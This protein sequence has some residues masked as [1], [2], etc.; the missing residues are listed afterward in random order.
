M[1][2]VLDRADTKARLFLALPVPAQA[3][4]RLLEAAARNFSTTIEALTQEQNLHVTLFFFGEVKNHAQYLGWLKQ[5]LPQA[6]VPTV[7]I[8]HIGRGAA[9]EQ[10]WAYVTP[11]AGLMA[12]RESLNEKLRKI[13]FPRPIQAHKFTPHIR[14]AT[15][16]PVAR[17][18]GI[19]DVAAPMTFAVPEAHLYKSELSHV[20][21]TYHI[22][23]S[24]A[25]RSR[26]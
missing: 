1:I 17:G 25:L 18:M 2:S 9:R 22:E 20:G 7:T 10:L 16:L 23:C 5:G 3:R 6:F 24:I 12:L 13:H 15:L 14:L 11:T 8:T 4:A 21:P 26:H 19:A